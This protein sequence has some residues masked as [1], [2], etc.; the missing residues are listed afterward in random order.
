MITPFTFYISIFLIISILGFWFFIL[1][2]INKIKFKRLEREYD[3]KEDKSRQGEL[4]AR[5]GKTKRETGRRTKRET[6]RGINGKPDKGAPIFDR[7][8]MSLGGN[9]LPDLNKVARDKRTV[10]KTSRSRRREKRAL[11]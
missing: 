11:L 2:L 5:D 4:F 6:G 9:L 7:E 3:E 8:V 10:K 1:W